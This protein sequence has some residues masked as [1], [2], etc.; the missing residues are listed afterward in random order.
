MTGDKDVTGMGRLGKTRTGR[1]R[2]GRI[3]TR[4]RRVR[5][6]DD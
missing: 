1:G 4:I 6:T 3:R 5:I 2:L